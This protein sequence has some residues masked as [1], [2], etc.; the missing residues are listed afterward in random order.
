VVRYNADGSLDAPFG[1][2][3][4][5]FTHLGPDD[6]QNPGP[7]CVAL[8]PDGKIL[9]GGNALGPSGQDFVLLRYLGHEQWFPRWW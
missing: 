1:K 7:S 2:G 3:G 8:Q 5:A 6:E 4:V 9:V